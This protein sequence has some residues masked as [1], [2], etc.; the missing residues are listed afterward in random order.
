MGMEPGDPATA[1]RI[2]SQRSAFWYV[3]VLLAALFGLAL[4][5]DAS[6]RN[7]ATY[8]E[9][10]YL[11][12]AARWWRTGDQDEIT[13]MGSPLTFWKLQQAPVYWVLDRCGRSAWIDD[14]IANQRSLL[15]LVR[16]G[17]VWIW[18]TAFALTIS[19]SRHSYGPRATA[20][21][22]W[23]FALSPNLIAHGTLVTMELPLVAAT[24][25]IFWLFWRFLETQRTPWFWG[26]A[27][28]SGL[29]F[30]CKFTT[31]LVPPILAVI[32]WLS[33]WQSADRRPVALTAHVARGMV[34]F[35]FLMVLANMA[36]TGFA[37]MPLSTSRGPHPTLANWFGAHGSEYL[38]QVYETPLPQDWV[39]FATQLHHQATGGA[40]YLWGQRRTQGWWYYYLVA[41]AVKVPVTVWVL[42]G[43]R[44]V[45][46]RSLDRGPSVKRP[47]C[48]LPVVILLY[49]VI[50][51]C[52][53]S[54]NYG[55]RYL[56]PL[57]PLAIVWLSALAE[58]RGGIVPAFAVACGLAG[59]AVAVAGIHPYEL[60]YFNTLAGGPLA[61]RHIL[62]DSNLD[63]GQGLISLAHIEREQPEFEDLTFYY[64]GDTDPAWYGIAGTHHVVNAVDDH[65]GL[66]SLD[67]VRSR[68]LAVSASLQ[69]GPWGP[70]GFFRILDRIEP[71]RMTADTTIAIY[72]TADMHAAGGR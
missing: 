71:V 60:T 69:W 25:A 62:S 11:R 23:L 16:I 68:Y 13:R 50:T 49:L 28:I 67:C 65:T 53:S 40:S 20:L 35:C 33:R 4:V 24:T 66:P 19:W 54:R 38:H 64:F 8:D 27:A 37:S 36:V 7:S 6:F 51:A 47:E 52:G 31:I 70:P 26:A 48:L 57:A 46:S 34:G 5:V 58:R 21:A 12:V 3:L 56:L 2:G 55:V 42:A 72:R 32:W 14:P 18:L 29:A 22:A 45:Q 41:L 17:S 59:G 9:V 10:A 1:R 39:G 61:G 15:P 43:T 30:S 44:L 63:W